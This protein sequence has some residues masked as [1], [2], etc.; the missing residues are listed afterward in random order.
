MLADGGPLTRSPR[1]TDAACAV[2]RLR[3]IAATAGRHAGGPAPPMWLDE[4]D[5]AVS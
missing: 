2:N 5:E 3:R 4:V 1:I